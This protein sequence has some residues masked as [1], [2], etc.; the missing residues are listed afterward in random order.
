[1]NIGGQNS[2][3]SRNIRGGIIGYWEM[4]AG[5]DEILG[6]RDKAP[7]YVNILAELFNQW[8]DR[9]QPPGQRE[10]ENI[11]S[12]PVYTAEERAAMLAFH[13]VFER[14]ADATTTDDLD[15]FLNSPQWLELSAAAGQS[16]A[17]FKKR[18]NLTCGTD[19]Q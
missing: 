15:A 10:M 1:M 13:C 5:R 18:G 9:F 2:S 19:L 8:E 3:A 17:V 7:A 12:E 16:L 6:Y 11:Y 14:V 4:L